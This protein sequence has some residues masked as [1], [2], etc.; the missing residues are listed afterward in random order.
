[1]KDLGFI[2]ANNAGHE[3]PSGVHCSGA[4]HRRQL[5]YLA[6]LLGAEEAPSLDPQCH[7]TARKLTPH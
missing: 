6:C 1:M 5:A 4:H 7:E 3:S 2:T